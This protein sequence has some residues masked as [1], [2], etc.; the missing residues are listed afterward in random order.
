MQ[1]ACKEHLLCAWHGAKLFA[2]IVSFNSHH[3]PVKSNYYSPF[4]IE[5]NE[6][7]QG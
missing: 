7:H 5:K 4:R 1:L 3:D 6:A 2:C